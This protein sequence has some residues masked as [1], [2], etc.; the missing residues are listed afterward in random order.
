ML[1]LSYNTR[2]TPAVTCLEL[3]Y[4]SETRGHFQLINIENFFYIYNL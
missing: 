4:L 1:V 2:I 3:W